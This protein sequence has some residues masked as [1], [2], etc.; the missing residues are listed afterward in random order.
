MKNHSIA[1]LIAVAFLTFGV[2]ASS[3]SDKAGPQCVEFRSGISYF[4]SIAPDPKVVKRT[5][6]DELTGTMA[7]LLVYIEVPD[8]NGRRTIEP[9]SRQLLIFP[10]SSGR[11]VVRFIS[12]PTIPEW[13]YGYQ[14]PF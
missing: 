13:F 4:D 3:A 8:D 12:M 5:T 6:L 1:T 7:R 11:H 14:A 10:T 9:E 2:S